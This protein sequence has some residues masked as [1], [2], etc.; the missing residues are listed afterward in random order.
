MKKVVIG[1]LIIFANLLF[2]TSVALAQTPTTTPIPLPSEADSTLTEDIVKIRQAVQ[3]KVQEKLQ[4]I[5]GSKNTKKGW[6]GSVTKI[7]DT[8]LTINYLSQDRII[9]VDPEAVIINDK[10]VKTTLNKIE[11]GHHI[12]A[13]GDLTHDGSLDTKRII[14][15]DPKT[16]V[17]RNIVVGKIADISKSSPIIVLIPSGNKNLQYQIKTDSST[18]SMSTTG[19]KVDL[20]TL[21]AGQRVIAILK[22][23]PKNP[24]TF[25]ALKFISTPTTDSITPT[26]TPKPAN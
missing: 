21:T 23:D 8:R 18:E 11:V 1:S 4:S 25:T 16:I 10:R 22:Q 26:P 6:I 24:N 13:M 17:K 19:T 9:N 15:Y 3:Q 7:E 2:S 20:K 5:T 14:Y 12:I